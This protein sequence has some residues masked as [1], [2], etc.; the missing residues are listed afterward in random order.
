MLALDKTN[1]LRNSSHQEVCSTGLV[2]HH[3]KCDHKHVSS[4]WLKNDTHRQPILRQ[5][6]FQQSHNS[7]RSVDLDTFK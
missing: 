6:T 3:G 2:Q 7:T 1:L 4:L 5:A